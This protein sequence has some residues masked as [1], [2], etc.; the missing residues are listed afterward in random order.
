MRFPSVSYWPPW[1]GQPKPAGEDWISRTGPFAVVSRDVFPIGPFACTGQPRCAQRFEMIVKLGSFLK[2]PLLRTNA[3][4]RET[5]PCGG[6]DHERRDQPLPLGEVGD[7]AEVDLVAPLVRGTTGS[8][9]KPATGTVT[10]PPISAPS[11]MVMLSRKRLRGYRSAV[12]DRPPLGDGLRRVALL[13]LDGDLL[14]VV[15]VHRVADP[16]EPEDDRDHRADRAD[17]QR[18]DDRGRRG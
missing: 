14:L 3:V 15:E 18:V 2:I 16:E 17:Q 6:I 4:R 7:R 10:T 1:H 11:P 9:A 8:S 13:R 5:S 12:G